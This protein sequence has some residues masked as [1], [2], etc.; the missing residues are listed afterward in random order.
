MK[1]TLI[2]KPEISLQ[3]KF[4]KGKSDSLRILS[5]S[6]DELRVFLQEQMNEHPYLQVQ[7]FQVEQDSD[8]YLEYDHSKRSL[9]D[10]VMEQ[11]HLYNGK[12]DEELCEYL[13]SQLDSNG[14]FRVKKDQLYHHSPYHKAQIQAHLNI[15]HTFEPVGIFAFDLKD[16]LQ[17]QCKNSEEADAQIAYTLCNYLEDL[18]LRRW[19]HIAEETHLCK[20]ELERGFHFIQT[21]NPKPAANYSIETIFVNPEFKID[22]VDETVNIQLLNDDLSLSFQMDESMKESKELTSFMRQQRALVK[23]LQQS[24]QKRNMT[25][26]Q[27]MQYICD[28]QH[29][30]FL[31]HGPLQHLTLAMIAQNCGLHVSTISRA[32]ANKSF[33]FEN[34]YYTLKK[35]LANGGSEQSV[36]EEIKKRLLVLI[37][38]ED[39]HHPYSDEDLRKLLENEG[40]LISRRAVSKYREACFIFN[41]SKRRIT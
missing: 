17:I 27:I 7:G 9:Y 29:D 12:I 5:Y 21:C 3:T 16:C 37:D 32:I 19:Q 6:N 25:L 15:L 28:V 13:L 4:H 40:I 14:Y 24:I 39:K 23:N 1:Q 36:K 30:F 26:L 8:A 2:P 31:N 38:E 41:S 33:E 20:E 10:E 22:V 35:M 18:A 11:V 34:K